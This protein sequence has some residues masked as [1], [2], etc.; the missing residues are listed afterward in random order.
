M[1]V[2]YKPYPYTQE[3]SDKFLKAD[4]TW[5][6]NNELISTIEENELV[7]AAALTNLD[8]RINSVEGVSH[9]CESLTWIELKEKRDDYDLIPGRYYRITDYVTTTAQEN[10]QSAEHP[11][12]IIVL[13]LSENTLSETA[14]AA[15]NEDDEYFGEAGVNLDAWELKYCLD[16]DTSRFAWASGMP[17]D[18]VT[19]STEK[20][21]KFIDVIYDTVTDPDAV[22]Y[23]IN[24]Q[25]YELRMY[26]GDGYDDEDVDPDDPDFPGYYDSGDYFVYIGT[27]NYEGSTR[28]VWRKSEGGEVTEV[29]ID[30][31]RNGYI[32][33]LMDTF[34][35]EGELDEESGIPLVNVIMA[36]G[37]LDNAPS[38]VGKGVIYYMK[39][40]WNNECPYD[41][42]NIQ[43][44]RKITDGRLDTQSGTDTWLYTF[45][46]IDENDNVN[47]ASIVC[48]NMSDDENVVH[49][50][51]SNS[52]GVAK[53]GS[54]VNDFSFRLNNNVFIYS[55]NYDTDFFYGIY[56]NHFGTDCVNNTFGSNASMNTFGCSAISN[57]FSNTVMENT[58]GNFLHSNNFGNYVVQN[59]FQ[60]IVT[61]NTFGPNLYGN[62]FGNSFRNNTLGN[63]V[64]Y[65]I[66]GNSVQNNQASNQ[67]N[68]NVIGNNIVG[69]I[70]NKDYIENII[71]E[72]GN[73]NI[74]LTSTQTTSSTQKLQYITIAQGV[75]YNGTRKTISHNTLNDTFRTVYQPVN[76]VTVSV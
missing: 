47:D 39:D 22:V 34:Y 31:N 72:S 26:K 71:V 1:A 7:T 44:K 42:K 16:N 12:D 29:D 54:D 20:D 46:W 6:D 43:F 18:L 49:G 51:Y 75:N 5:G 59:V 52:M 21:D 73:G 32:Y 65:N 23:T 63:H 62:M 28:Y 64:S 33:I 24:G 41:F 48:Q 60:H 14:Y 68:Y 69:L 9:H 37:D 74:T 25:Q 15:L 17:Y 45:T 50:V 70:F 66:I 40:E 27:L 11:F 13:A 30:G 3:A 4:G 55:Y 67:F 56:E 36:F 8:S 58:F 35:D 53:N 2:N 57:V 76:S 10:T 38:E 19:Y 61:N